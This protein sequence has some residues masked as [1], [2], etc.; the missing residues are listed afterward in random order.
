[1]STLVTLITPGILP[2]NM[3]MNM[4]G[5]VHATG[6]A[7]YEQNGQIPS[8]KR[9]AKNLLTKNDMSKRVF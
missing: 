5:T 9:S 7:L 1:M 3:Y 6:L 4:N 2:G 8:T